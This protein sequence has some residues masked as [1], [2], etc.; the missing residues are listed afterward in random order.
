M[1]KFGAALAIS[2]LFTTAACGGG[3]GGRPSTDDISKALKGKAGSSLNITGDVGSK[4]IKCI[5]KVLEDSKISDKGLRAIVDADK[6][7]KPSKSDEAQ[8]SDVTTKM[9]KCAPTQ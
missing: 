6:N 7:F 2:V 5:A 8:I 3:G 1:R 4:A 9:E